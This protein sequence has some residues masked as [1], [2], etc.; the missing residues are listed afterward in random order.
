MRWGGDEMLLPAWGD[1]YFRR[2][3]NAWIA[4]PRA[5]P[6]A[7]ATC[8]VAPGATPGGSAAGGEGVEPMEMEIDEVIRRVVAHLAASYVPPGL[9]AAARQSGARMY[10]CVRGVEYVGTSLRAVRLWER[11]VDL[12][13]GD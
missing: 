3:I 13:R 5:D 8:V 12:G 11:Q 4:W 2:H 6:G 1:F 9:L 10:L 7:S